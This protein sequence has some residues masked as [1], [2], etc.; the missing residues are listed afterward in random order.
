[1][2]AAVAINTLNGKSSEFVGI[3]DTGT[4]QTTLSR[5][6]LS[7]LGIDPFT[8][9]EIE[10]GGAEGLV[11]ALYCDFIRVGFLE[12]P[13]LRQ[14]FPVGTNPVPVH[15]SQGP[16]NLLGQES[17]LNRC[18]LTFDGPGQIVTIDF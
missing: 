1:M 11:K 6:L 4:D 10:V 12:V 18:L 3:V 8:L 7:K 15:F 16:F 5:A 14:H 17:F 13:G 9:K 2:A